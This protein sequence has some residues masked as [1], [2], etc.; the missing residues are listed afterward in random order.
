MVGI[1]PRKPDV[2]VFINGIPIAVIELKAPGSESTLQ[3]AFNQLQTYKAQIPALFNTNG[4]LVISDGLT[5]RIGSLTSDYERF[6]P[7]RTVDGEETGLTDD[8][9]AFYDA[10]AE[11]ESAVQVLGNDTLKAIAQE[12]LKSIKSNISVDWARKQSARAAL[13]L[14]VK[15]ILKKYGYPPDFQDGAVKTVL[16]QA[17][18]L[19]AAWEDVY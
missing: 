13:R 16:Q 17:E 19:C 5:A 18:S 15:K 4:L 1:Q 11:N 3:S 9:I 6:M 2:V 7:W 10:L 14:G 8:E 12:L